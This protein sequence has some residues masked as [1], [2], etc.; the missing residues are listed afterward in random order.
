MIKVLHIGCNAGTESMPKY[1]RE[2]CDYSELR[3]DDQLCINLEK[4]VEIPDVVFIQIQNEN[5][6]NNKTVQ[7]IGEQVNSLR[8]RG[9]FVINWTGDKRNGVPSWMYSFAKNVNITGFSN[10]EDVDE[11]N[12]KV[13][14]GAMF[15]QQGIDTEIFKPNGE[16]ANVPDIV[17]LANDYGNQFPLSKYRRD[18]VNAL[19]VKYGTR[20]KVYGNGWRD[21]GNVNSSQYEEAKVYRGCKIA[22]SCSHYDSDRYFSDRLGR[23]LCSG[24]FVLSHHYKGIEKDFEVDKHLVSFRDINEMIRIIDTILADDDARNE[25]AKEGCKLASKEFSYRN[26][27]QQICNLKH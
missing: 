7:F 4:I 26:I 23:A 12:S 5:I 22:I 25:I 15:L 20:F 24:A 8:E 1:F 18:I 9:S 10:Q 14:N 13:S 27:V 2:V 3:L 11:F 16:S 21:A 6:G 17:F 19:K